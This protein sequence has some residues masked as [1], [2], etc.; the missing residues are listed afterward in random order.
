MMPGDFTAALDSLTAELAKVGLV[1]E[2]TRYQ[3]VAFRIEMA[4]AQV[5]Y[6]ICL[7]P[8]SLARGVWHGIQAAREGSI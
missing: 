3:K 7:V 1:R 8:F 5:V 6:A 4:V 2:Q